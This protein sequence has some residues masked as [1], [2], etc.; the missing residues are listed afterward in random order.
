MAKVKKK[1]YVFGSG[2]HAKSCT[3]VIESDNTNKIIGI[4]YKNKKPSDIFFSN[5]K[6]INET[7]LAS[8]YK[9]LYAINGIG[10]IKSNF[11]RK[12]IFKLIKKKKFKIEPTS[13]QRAYISKTSKVGLGT[14]VMHNS[15]IGPKSR[16]GN[17]CIINTGSIIEHDAKIGNHCHISTGCIIN[18]NVSISNNCFVGS[19]TIIKEGVKIKPGRII[20]MGSVI[21]KD[22]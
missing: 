3:D 12:E 14:I 10:Q 18:G 4:V 2:G 13:S 16:I 22:V 17:N 1:F 19:G 21:K 5:Y 6:L 15:Y 9:G 20:P 8:S 11:A 7:K